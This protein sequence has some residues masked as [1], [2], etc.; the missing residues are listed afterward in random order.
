MLFRS[1]I[2]SISDPIAV[3]SIG[4]IP[5]G[6]IT[7]NFFGYDNGYA[8]TD[9]IKPTKG[10]WIKCSQ[11]G[12]MVLSSSGQ[13][14][15]SN[16]INIVSTT[17]LPPSPPSSVIATEL[18]VPKAF[19][20]KQNFPNPFNP[21]TTISYDLPTNAIVR[22]RVYNM[23]GEE[24]TSLVNGYKPAG[25]YRAQFNANN[26]ASGIYLVRIEAI[27]GAHPKNSFT[28]TRKMILLK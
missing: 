14:P 10:Y 11:D 6:M 4:S 24:I 5:S 17:E 23:L 16:R 25:S 20:L 26:I 8:I 9:T 28:Q 19:T 15:A 13:I 2:G 1:L 21:S 3:S 22:L 7:S 18:N 27:D 12:Q